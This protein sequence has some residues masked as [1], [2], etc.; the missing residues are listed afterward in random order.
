M[1]EP[2]VMEALFADL[3]DERVLMPLAMP[4]GPDQL[5]LACNAE[6]IASLLYNAL[7]VRVVARG[8]V[9]A[10]VRHVKL[11]GLLCHATPGEHKDEVALEI[12]GPYTLF[13]HTR[14]YGRSLSSL[15]P[16]LA[17]CHTYRLEAAW[18]FGGGT[19]V[20]RLVLRSGDPIAARDLAR[21]DSK[22]EERSTAKGRM[23][24]AGQMQL[25]VAMGDHVA[26]PHGVAEA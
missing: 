8:Q 21:F 2:S 7:R 10:V 24:Q 1:P 20:G 14:I 17:W 13:R 3:P 15:V 4:L 5:A 26:K 9:R 6:I 25:G 11:M 19:N 16:R 23:V 22:V 18:A 12:S